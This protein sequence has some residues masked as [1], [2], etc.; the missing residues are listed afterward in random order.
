MDH[1]FENLGPDRFQQLVQALL[2]T[3]N[4]KTICFPI[5][6]PDGGRDAV[7]PVSFEIGKDEFIVFQVK[8]SRQPATIEDVSKWLL[9]KASGELEKIERLKVRGATQYFLVTNVSGTAHLDSGSID[10]TL[11]ALRDEVGIPVHCWFR[12]DL[13]R[14]LDGQ[15]DIKLRY[16]EVLS[17]HDFF[18]ILVESAPRDEHERRLIALRAFLADQ[19]E[20]DVQVKFK[21][22]ELQNKLLDL[23]ID[24]PFRV[25]FRTK[26]KGVIYS[27]Y[28]SAHDSARVFYD[29]N[30][31]ILT[32]R[33]QR[34]RYIG[35]CKLAPWRMG[36]STPAPSG[37]RGSAGTRKIDTCPIRL[38]SPSHPHSQQA[39][40]FRK[41]SREGSAV[42]A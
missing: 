31:A 23:F 3:A 37:R 10:K 42:G 33:R 40:R 38:P 20:E 18:R 16:P 5:G 36:T 41:A 27:D 17:G 2:M 21:Q 22:V 6:Q 11:T 19:Y 35:Y 25:T 39:E 26:D 24:L 4:T 14:L 32:T 34:R 8:Y 7:L 29:D 12:D 13:N 1:S 15:W 9:E 28:R 30:S